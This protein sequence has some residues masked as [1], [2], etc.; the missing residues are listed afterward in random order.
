MKPFQLEALSLSSAFLAGTFD[1]H[2]LL[3]R[4]K[5]IVSGRK[6]WLRGLITRV[7]ERFGTTRPRERQLV[8]F[9][10]C[11]RGF[12]AATEERQ[13]GID[14]YLGK[15]AFATV[16]A[17]F[18]QLSV[19]QWSTVAELA[20]WLELDHGDLDWFADRKNLERISVDG[21][22]RHYRYRW[23]RK[24]GGQSRLIEAP[25]RRLKDIQRWLLSDLLNVIPVHTAA[26]GFRMG[27]SVRS[28]VE[29]HVGQAVVLKMDLQ[30][31]FPS[32]QPARLVG[33]LM[34]VGYPEDVA[35][36]ITA[37]C[38]NYVPSDVWLTYPQREQWEELRRC[39]RLLQRPH[40]PQGAPTSPTIANLCAYR[41]D[42]R[43]TG[44]AQSVGANYTRYADDLLF[45]GGPE[46]KRQ[47]DRFHVYVAAIAIDEGFQVN[48][49]KTRIM[50]QSLRQQAAGVVLNVKPNVPRHDYD[51]LKAVLHRSIFEGPESQNHDRHHDRHHDF[52]RHLEGR[53]NYV[54]QWNP[55]R[56]A[57]LMAL[58]D[59]IA[60]DQMESD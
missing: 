31:F 51:Q 52:R 57:K 20:H 34:S 53:I 43:L 32:I 27:R 30:D 33:L 54:G 48:F 14:S 55:Q 7:L 44:L 23:V 18:N 24:R 26:H 36:T 6:Q 59:K 22:L 1:E 8:D 35:R 15:P 42:C 16:D 50:S 58:F 9:V 12:I 21:P 40:F 45:S 29:P 3:D 47:V 4:S 25:K 46:F 13:V 60:W 11:D 56:R 39:E 38:S 28:F 2:G 41:L 37:L 10:M 17:R 19:P 5:S 49:H